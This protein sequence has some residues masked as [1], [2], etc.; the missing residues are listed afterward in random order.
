VKRTFEEVAYH[1]SSNASLINHRHQN[2]DCYEVIQIVKGEGT[3]YF[4]DRAYPIREGMLLFIDAANLHCISPLDVTEYCRSK[5]ILDKQYLHGIFQSMQAMATLERFFHHHGGACFY[6]PQ[7]KIQTADG[8]FQTMHESLIL[9][10]AEVNFAIISALMQLFALCTHTSEQ[11]KPVADDSMAPVLRYLCAHYGEPLTLEQ[12]AEQTHLS[13]YYLCRLFR[14]HTG[15]TIMQYLYEH[16]LSIARQQLILTDNSISTI[17]MDC[18]FSNSSHFC[19]LFK[20]K[21]GMSPKEYR[22]KWS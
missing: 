3:V 16:R 12:I 4:L 9:D 8:L 19:A 18:G 13:K 22:K 17:A 10:E 2:P 1:Q 21:E 7:S 20:Q 6:L 15:L 14:R 11:A 5:L